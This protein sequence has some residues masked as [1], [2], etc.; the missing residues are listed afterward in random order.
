MNSGTHS[1]QFSKKMKTT[2]HFFTSLM[3]IAS[4]MFISCNK[5]DYSTVVAE[6]TA[7]LQIPSRADDNAQTMYDYVVTIGIKD[8]AGNDLVAPL[9]G[10]RWQP[11]GENSPWRGEINPDEYKL[12]I[13]LSNPN[14]QYDN[15]IYANRAS[16]F[17]RGRKDLEHL[18]PNFRLAQYA[19]DYRWLP[20]FDNATLQDYNFARQYYLLSSFSDGCG[21]GLQDYLTYRFSC[22]AIFGDDTCHEIVVYWAEEGLKDANSTMQQFPVCTKVLFDGEE[23]AF[24]NRAYMPKDFRVKEGKAMLPRDYDAAFIDIVL[25]K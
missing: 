25:D 9:K 17:V 16:G 7:E 11:E 12:D 24:A 3:A 23:I 22:P 6:Q 19:D 13:I 2:K 1:K 5:V 15:S 21:N 14:D 8:A 10:D 20:Y 18:R 4:M